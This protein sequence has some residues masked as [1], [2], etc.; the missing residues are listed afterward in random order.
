MS[1]TLC[2][3]WRPARRGSCVR[4]EVIVLLHPGHAVSMTPADGGIADTATELLERLPKVL[5][6][7]RAATAI[8]NGDE[9]A[10]VM[11]GM[12]RTK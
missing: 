1:P 3:A 12:L 10:K 7:T 2:T 4:V 11:L 8:P 9:I 5:V 6:G